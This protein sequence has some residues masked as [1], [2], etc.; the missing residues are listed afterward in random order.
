[1]N[2]IDNVI[3]DNIPETKGPLYL[4]KWIGSKT[5]M[6]KFIIDK[7]P[8]WSKDQIYVEPFCGSASVFLNLPKPYC[9]EVL[10][11]LDGEIINFFR[12]LQDQENF[13]EFIHRLIWTPYSLDEFR[14]A[15][16]IKKSTDNEYDD[17]D[18][19][20]AFFVGQC[21]G[22]SGNSKTE[23]NWGRK[24]MSQHNI[25]ETASDWRRFIKNLINVHERLSAVQLDNRDAL[26]VIKYWDTDK[27]IFY[28]DP[29]Y[30][31]S[32]RTKSGQKLYSHEMDD[33]QHNKLINAL[34]DVKGKVILSGYD[35]DMYHV[36]DSHGWNRYEK[37]LMCNMTCR[38]RGSGLK[39][40]GSGTKDKS[41]K[42]IVWTNFKNIYKIDDFIK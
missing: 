30:M 2:Y 24:F 10:N 35:S 13:H 28:I 40:D 8:P 6:A 19:A 18:R 7:F 14:R 37:N 34:L 11:D 12:V 29:P 41:R 3:L 36:L 20:W 25:S 9:V 32:T 38:T 15:L 23:G 33:D 16:A 31:L 39:S 26:T 17:I 4:F 21:Q 27:T 22:L 1:M 42:E 5:R